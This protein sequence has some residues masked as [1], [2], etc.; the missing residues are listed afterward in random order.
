L[1]LLAETT[2]STKNFS[3]K[4]YPINTITTR[5]DG[6]QYKKIAV[7]KWVLVSGNSNKEKKLAQ[8]TPLI[9]DKHLN[10][11]KREKK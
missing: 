3:N 5:K 7:G 11:S 1:I 9:N 6:K 8:Q 10:V 4:K 2:Q